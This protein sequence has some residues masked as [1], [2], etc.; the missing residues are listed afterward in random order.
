M[1]LPKVL[2]AGICA[3]VIGMGVGRF[4]YTPLLPALQ[5]AAGMGNHAAGIL[6]SINYVGYL[7]GSLG[8][9]ALPKRWSR[10]ALFRVALLASIGATIL[11]ALAPDP[12]LWAVSRFIAG[13]ASAAVLILSSEIVVRTLQRH[14][15]PAL[16]GVHFAGVGTGIALT[17]IVTALLGDRLGWAG[18]WIVLTILSLALA[19]LCWLWLIPPKD[20][21]PAA[22]TGASTVPASLV[23]LLSLAIAYFCEGAGYVV[24]ATF[25]V[26]IVKT[27]PALSNVAPWFWVAVGL[28]GAPSAIIWSRI[29][30]RIGLLPALVLAH[31]VQTVGIVAPVLSQAPA[32]VLVSAM[33]F[34][35]TVVGITALVVAYASR[36]AGANAG[37]MIGVL[38]ASFSVGQIIGPIVAGMLAEG[39]RGFDLPLVLAGLTV[40]VG[41]VVL[42]A[43]AMLG[44]A[45]QEVALTTR[46]RVAP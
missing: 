8:A 28:A 44:R 41:A 2:V 21:R 24:T 22:T 45:A 39:G 34:G 5:D 29:G 36:T 31:L 10:V 38:T 4:A 42:A 32:I 17:G 18:G 46:N 20:D 37:R 27:M 1:T 25:L 19:P 9:A 33:L 26:A 23:P 7:V 40:A 43:G 13:I 35:G 30:A 16:V 15:R 3:L 6:A 14:R 12:R 11:M